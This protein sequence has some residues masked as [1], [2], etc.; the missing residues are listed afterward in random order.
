MEDKAP[1]KFL[2][3]HTPAEPLSLILHNQV[4]AS[5]AAIFNAIIVVPTTKGNYFLIPDA[6]VERTYSNEA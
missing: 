4:Y 3:S 5:S 1:I 2:L 6:L